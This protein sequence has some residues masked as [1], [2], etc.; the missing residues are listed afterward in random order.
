M[1][2]RPVVLVLSRQDL[3]TLDRTRYAPADRVRDGVLP[4]KVRARLAVEAGATQGWWR[5]VGDAGDVIGV[6]R[7]GAS[8]PGDTN[9]REYGFSVDHVCERALKLLRQLA[10]T[11]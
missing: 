10:A 5:Y 1:R 11:R 4:P 7:F 2:E 6:D 3:P 8:A 9:L